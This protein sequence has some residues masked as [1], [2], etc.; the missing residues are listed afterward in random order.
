MNSAKLAST[1]QRV[2]GLRELGWCHEGNCEVPCAPHASCRPFLVWLVKSAPICSPTRRAAPRGRCRTT[3]TKATRDFW[4]VVMPEGGA[5]DVGAAD[6][7]CF[8]AIQ[9]NVGRAGGC[10]N[11][12][13]LRWSDSTAMSNGLSEWSES[14]V[15]TESTSSIRIDKVRQWEMTETSERGSSITE[16]EDDVDELTLA[17]RQLVA[18]QQSPSETTAS[19]PA[20]KAK[21]SRFQCDECKALFR[22]KSY[23]RKHV[24]AVHKK[25][26]PYLC[27][28][29]HKAFGY[30]GAR[31][32]HHRT[33]HLGQ[34]P[35][36]C[37]H[38]TCTMRF[39]EK[40]NMKKHYRNRHA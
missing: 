39:S 31:A 9:T 15:R 37:V 26:K 23:L 8:G 5:R 14:K 33:I 25:L 30:K 24:N 11:G 34:K 10:G 18:L 21:L 6:R 40:G 13:G 2:R 19:G 7:S 1:S 20:P 16:S 22:R 35:F 27:G 36:V 4:S 28:I 17:A 32:K 29:C 12:T 38:P 3:M